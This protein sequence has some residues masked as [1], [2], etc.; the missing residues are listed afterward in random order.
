MKKVRL[1]EDFIAEDAKTVTP[2]SDIKIDDFSTDDG[3][4]LKSQ[5]I[6]G[7][8]VSSETEKEFKEYFFDQY[9]NTAFTEADM[10]NLVV[11][12]NEYLE[13]ITAK[14]TEEEEEEKSPLSTAMI[15]FLVFVVAGSS[16]FQV[17]SSL[18]DPKN[19]TD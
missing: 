3:I 15:A 4:E 1:Y 18:M 10:Q 5:E 17:I 2:D 13:E 19:R 9:G 11:M 16:L 12:Y 7:A 6:I 8:I 14:E